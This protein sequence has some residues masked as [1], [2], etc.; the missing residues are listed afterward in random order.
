M[1]EENKNTQADESVKTR[2]LGQDGNELTE[3]QVDLTKGRLESEE[4]VVAHH[5]AV[6]AVPAKTH[7]FPKRVFFNV[8]VDEDGNSYYPE[9]AELE[10]GDERIKVV[11]GQFVWYD[12]SMNVR[13]MEIV[14]YT[15]EE[16]VAGKEAYDEKETI[17]RYIPFTEE[18]LETEKAKEEAEKQQAEMDAKRDNLVNVVDELQEAL[19]SVSDK[20]DETAEAIDQLVIAIAEMVGE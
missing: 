2:I 10:D 3:E 5:E 4:I 16:G 20:T 14:S 12:E 17:Q 6:A 9:T 8:S 1:A 18:E 15:D 13:G 19:S 7:T 11:N